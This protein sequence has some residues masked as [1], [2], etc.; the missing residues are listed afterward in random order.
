VVPRRQGAQGCPP[1]LVEPLEK[2]LTW[3]V[4]CT[5]N[6]IGERAGNVAI[7]EMVMALKTRHDFDGLTSR[8]KIERPYPTSRMVSTATGLKVVSV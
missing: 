8:I 4:E 2:E 5:I 6:R 7:E 3:R 1:N